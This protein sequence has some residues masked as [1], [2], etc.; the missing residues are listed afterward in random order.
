MRKLPPLNALRAFEAAARHLSFKSAAE[1]LFV[2]P[3][4]I[5]HQIKL[6][7]QL[8]GQQLFR[9]RPRPISLTPAGMRLFPVLRDGFDSFAST[10]SALSK[11]ADNA[12]LRVSTTTAF[13]SRWLLPR[14][15]DWNDQHSNLNLE[16]VATEQVIDLR[17][18][19]ID[20]AIRYAKHPPTDLE[21][22]PLFK[23][24]FLPVCS[25]GL[26]EGLPVDDWVGV[27]T[28]LTLLHFQWKQQDDPDA[29]SWPLWRAMARMVDRRAESIDPKRGST[30]SEEHMTIE[31][32]IAGQGVA[33]ASS[34]LV[35]RELKMGLLKRV[36]DV[37]IPGRTFYAV[38]VRSSPRKQ[39]FDR[40]VRWARD[41][42][43]AIFS[44]D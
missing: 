16:V 1:E 22:V 23:D 24:R 19:T 17:G 32:A 29:P 27:L 6:L 7:E 31:A 42:N 20:M 26:L 30:L 9:R 5:S 21:A 10:V 38:S 25:P 36:S 3:T 14:L 39:L 15:G 2:T 44:S 40:F 4:A 8:T 41:D 18:G 28:K 13:A 37:S 43:S 33:L 34:V 11:E 35:E 12:P